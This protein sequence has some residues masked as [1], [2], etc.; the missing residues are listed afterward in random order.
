[1]KNILLFTLTLFTQVVFGQVITQTRTAT[2]MDGDYALEGTVYLELYDDG[3]LN[4][5][6]GTDYLTQTNVFDVHV[7]LTNNNDYSAPI[8]TAGMLLVQN[9]GTVSGLNYSSGSMTFNLPSA[10]SI[11][12]YQH[13][14]LI[15]MQFGQL[16]WGNGE[17]EEPV[18]SNMNATE[19]ANE[20]RIHLY[21]NPTESGTVEIQFQNLQQNILVEVLNVNGQVISSERVLGKQQHI[22]ELKDRG[23]YFLRL[24]ATDTSVVKKII[25]L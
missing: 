20:D 3:T 8:D 10:V 24:T 21:P 11:N 16:H 5:R 4:L 23:T 22:V 7:F 25:R 17:F 18:S 12:D 13:I 6:F 9:I 19:E 15:C 2:L 14:V 1:M